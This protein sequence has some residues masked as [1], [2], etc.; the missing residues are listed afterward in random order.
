ML[1]ASKRASKKR[2]AGEDVSHASPNKKLK[3]QASTGSG[4]DP[5]LYEQSLKLPD[6]NLSDEELAKITIITNRAP[7]VLAFAVTLLKYT[8]PEQPLSSRLS[9]AQ[10]VVS[11]NSRSKAVSLGI[12]SGK[13]AEE[14][15]WGQGQPVVRVLGREIKVMKRSGYESQ[16]EEGKEESEGQL[17]TREPV[18]GVQQSANEQPALWGIDLE[19]LKKSYKPP[20]IGAAVGEGLPIYTAQSARNYLLKSFQSTTVSTSN[21]GTAA[22]KST[23]ETKAE[24]ELNLGYLLHALDLLYQSWVPTLGPQ[25]LDRRA[26]GWYIAV[27]PKVE[28]GVAGWGGKGNVAMSHILDLIR[29]SD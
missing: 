2:S 9:L 11:A 5:A 19:A 28:D 27:R 13:S 8:M 23:G 1:N 17:Q 25:E 21:P 26:W 4:P 14:E 10:A 22:K 7:L 3:N 24:K 18:E 16:S 20:A 15:G 6:C 12:E 29:K